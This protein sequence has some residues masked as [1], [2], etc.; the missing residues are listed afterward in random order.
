MDC[1]KVFINIPLQ[2]FNER[3]NFVYAISKLNI[4][5][6]I[7]TLE[8]IANSEIQKTEAINS[9]VYQKNGDEITIRLRAIHGLKSIAMMGSSEAENGLFKLL[10]NNCFSINMAAVEGLLEINKTNINRIKLLLSKD[11][12]MLVETAQSNR[13][14][15]YCNNELVH[16]KI[17][18]RNS[19]L[20]KSKYN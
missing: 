11:K 19:N 17:D 2:N 4:P 8:N 12:Q 15:N 6:L 14:T 10:K 20:L 18:F 1:F 16:D 7:P 13:F 5:E 3:W 9:S